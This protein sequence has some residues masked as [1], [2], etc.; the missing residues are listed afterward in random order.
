[1]TSFP[2]RQME[3]GRLIRVRKCRGAL[4][5]VA[6][7]VALPDPDAAID[8]IRKD[9][10]SV[11]DDLLKYLNLR[12]GEFIRADA[13]RQHPDKRPAD[14]LRSHPSLIA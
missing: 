10:S 14:E 13:T 7:I 9:V 3:L 11:S 8:L 2:I 5:L 12:S 6:Y 4:K 1:M